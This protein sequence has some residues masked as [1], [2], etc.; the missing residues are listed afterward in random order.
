MSFEKILGVW[1]IDEGYAHPTL[2]IELDR[3]RWISWSYGAACPTKDVP[4]RIYETYL[5]R[6]SRSGEKSSDAI[7]RDLIKK[8]KCGRYEGSRIAT[9]IIK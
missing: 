5:G 3:D 8:I 7:R 9:G 4:M 1:C 2:I 6:H